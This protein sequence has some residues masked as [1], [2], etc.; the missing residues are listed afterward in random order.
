MLFRGVVLG[1]SFHDGGGPRADGFG[2]LERSPV[3][4]AD[5][6]VAAVPPDGIGIGGAVE[7]RAVC[8]GRFTLTQI[9][10]QAAVPHTVKHSRSAEMT[11]SPGNIEGWVELTEDDNGTRF[12]AGVPGGKGGMACRNPPNWTYRGTGPS[13]QGNGKA[14]ECLKSFVLEAMALC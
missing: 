3:G 12:T 11:I 5:A 14:L 6:A 7:A 13:C 1:R 10:G 4:E 8:S 2:G 9:E